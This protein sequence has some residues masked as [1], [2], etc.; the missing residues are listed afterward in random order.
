MAQAT[1]GGVT[2]QAPPG[3]HPCEHA[4][5]HIVDSYFFGDRYATPASRRIFCDVCRVQRW[6][7][8]EAALALAEA[9]LGMIPAAAAEGIAGAA[10]L[11]AID[12]VAVRAETERS[13]HSLVGLL[14]VLQVACPPGAGEYVHFGA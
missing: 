5:G 9:E 12:L 10:R 8:V 2:T 6:L 13:G 1:P 14:R 4:R 11:G 3:G 7:D